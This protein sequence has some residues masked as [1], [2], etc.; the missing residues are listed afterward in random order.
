[1]PFSRPTLT[2]L[3]QQVVEDIQGAGIEGVTSLLRFSVL[4]V[5]G[6]ALAGLA[7]LHYGYLDW[8]AK[9]AVPWTAEGIYLE[10][11]GALKSVTRKPATYASG[12]VSFTT[13]GTTVIPAG[14]VIQI[15]GG[16]GGVAQSDGTVSNGIA[17]VTCIASISGSSGNAPVGSIATLGTSVEGIQTSGTV[18][19]AFTGGADEEGDDDLKARIIDAYSEGGQNGNSADYAA[20]AKD[21]SGVTRAWTNPNGIGLGSVVVY[22]MFD[23]VRS[24]NGGFPQG[25]NGAAIGESRY[26]TA[27]GDQLI[28]ANAIYPK[29]PVTALVVVCSPVAQPVNFSI[30]DLGAGNTTA[31]QTA[32]QE[33][34]SD[35]FT[36]LSRPGG[37][38]YQ[39]AWMEALSALDLAQFSVASPLESIVADSVGAMP[40]LGTITYVS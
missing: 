19:S 6:M 39:S 1:M 20:W 38:L 24:N 25:T 12:V 36:R 23:E 37:T 18:S 13:S 27:A 35:M 5:L 15:S 16:V 17:T 29:R 8:I 21:V 26:A 9:Q 31:N 28:V 3:R 33:A 30:A 14:T 7:H 2:E 11:W 40:T 34:L 22:V 32:I 4:Y 10:A